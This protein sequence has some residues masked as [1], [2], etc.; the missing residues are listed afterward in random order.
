M[1]MWTFSYT[2][3]L[4]G[5]ITNLDAISKGAGCH[6]LECVV[7][8]DNHTLIAKQWRK[9]EPYASPGARFYKST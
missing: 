2:P 6:I 3:A 7:A 5:R 8:H 9:G 1:K 4:D